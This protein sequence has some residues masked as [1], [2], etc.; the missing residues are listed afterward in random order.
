MSENPDPVKSDAQPIAT[1]TAPAVPDVDTTLL[2][3]IGVITMIK[4]VFG[5]LRAM[6]YDFSLFNPTHDSDSVI[7]VMVVLSMATFISSIILL[8]R[9]RIGWGLYLVA[10]GAQSIFL[11]YQISLSPDYQDF[12]AIAPIALGLIALALF[13]LAFKPSVR[14]GL[15]E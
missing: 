1:P 5:W 12:I 9:K 3:A 15:T 7:A 10:Q 6:F 2:T 13:L 14:R 4:S 11:L 8:G